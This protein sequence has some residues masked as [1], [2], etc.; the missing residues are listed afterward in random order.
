[1][2]VSNS[3]MNARSV[4][5]IG[6]SIALLAVFVGAGGCSSTPAAKESVFASPDQAIHALV[7]AAATHDTQRIDAVLGPG[8]ADVLSSGDLVAD[9]ADIERVQELLAE[10]IDFDD[11]EDGSLTALLGAD[12]WSFPIPLVP[13]H[14]GKGSDKS[15][16]EWRFDLEAGRTEIIN[17]RVG[18]NEIATIETLHAYVDAQREYQ[19]ESRDGRPPAYAQRLRSQPGKHDGLYWDTKES[20]LES[21]LG[22]LLAEAAAEGYTGE[23]KGQGAYHGYRFRVLLEQGAHAPGGAKKYIDASGN[24]TGGFAAIAWPAKYENS[25]VM[26]FLVSQRGMVYQKDLGEKTES[27]VASIQSFDPDSSW[28]PTT[29]D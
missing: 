17:R 13:V 9:R 8:G 12:G 26:T 20:E 7:E 14:E 10:K 15:K 2:F 23:N 18:R 22:P 24:M 28:S 11:N 4:L 25:G 3:I 19:S 27:S 5:T 1:M 16:D 21:P 29:D 6:G